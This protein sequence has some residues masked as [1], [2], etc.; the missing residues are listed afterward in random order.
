MANRPTT[1]FAL[2]TWLEESEWNIRD[3]HLFH[4]DYFIDCINKEIKSKI[5]E[6]FI[7]YQ[8]LIEEAKYIEWGCAY[9][10]SD[11]KV[12]IVSK[13]LVR[14]THWNELLC[15]SCKKIGYSSILLKN[16]ISLH[17]EV[18]KRIKDNLDII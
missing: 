7:A 8:N 9:C 6:P 18:S 13:G 11:I 4:S 10:K 12:K 3:M 14:R 1:K 16:L 15:N 5:S 2:D 17:K